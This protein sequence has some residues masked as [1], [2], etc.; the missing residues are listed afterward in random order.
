MEYDG[1]NGV[2]PAQTRR[3]YPGRIVGRPEMPN[4]YRLPHNIYSIYKETHSSLCN[5]L[6][7]LSGVGIRAIVEA[8]CIEK[9]AQGNSLQQRINSLAQMNLIT[10]DAANILHSLRFMGNNAVH[11]M[12]A[13]TPEELYTAF[14]VAEY[15]LKGVYI[16]PSQAASLPR[17]TS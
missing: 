9:Q 12:K 8:V 5:E 7:I 10:S 4:A 11:E 17:Q 16:I 3:V 6:S 2:K 14:E 15:L 1:D 13:H